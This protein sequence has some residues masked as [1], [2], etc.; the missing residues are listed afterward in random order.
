MAGF[1]IA[2]RIKDKFGCLMAVGLTAQVGLQ[3]ILKCAVVTNTVPNT[4]IGLPF[5]LL[6]GNRLDD[7]SGPDG[8][9]PL[10]PRQS[11]LE[12]GITPS[13]VISARAGAVG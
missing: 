7:A 11:S 9:R 10:H 13:P 3:T 6:R 8:D 12:R 4:G 2:L 5:L 1:V